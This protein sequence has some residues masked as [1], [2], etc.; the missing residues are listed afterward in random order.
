MGVNSTYLTHLLNNHRIRLLIQQFEP[1]DGSESVL[2]VKYEGFW[3]GAGC[4]A[5]RGTAAAG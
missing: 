3:F 5:E 1:P 4:W 2:S